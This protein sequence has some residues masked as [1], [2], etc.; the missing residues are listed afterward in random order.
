MDYLR[1][2]EEAQ[3]IQLADAVIEA[4]RAAGRNPPTRETWLPLPN[5]RRRAPG[6]RNRASCARSK[7]LSIHRHISLA[8]AK[9]KNSCPLPGST[10]P[11][12]RRR[13]S[14]P[15]RG[16]RAYPRRA[17]HQLSA[18]LSRRGA[19]RDRRRGPG[20]G[21]F[22]LVIAR[23]FR[24]D[25]RLH[26]P[27]RPHPRRLRNPGTPPQGRSS[28]T[29]NSPTAPPST[30]S[31]GRGLGNILKGKAGTSRIFEIILHNGL[32]HLGQ[33]IRRRRRTR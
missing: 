13:L 14:R 17:P 30:A 32:R 11:R 24:M 9:E 3:R 25:P 20:Q 7:S 4:V 10:H 23:Q 29:P 6:N 12:K 5:P 19:G 26:P 18:R 8:S 33:V 22:R 1:Q 31:S 27:L 16:R 15:G 21:L 2:L 28:S